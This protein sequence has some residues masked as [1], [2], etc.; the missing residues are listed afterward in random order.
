MGIPLRILL[1]SALVFS[2]AA[3]ADDHPA[4][5][6]SRPIAL[7]ELW[8]DTS[9]THALPHCFRIYRRIPLDS[10]LTQQL[11]LYVVNPRTWKPSDRRPAVVFIHGGGW[12]QG[13]PDQWFPQC[14]YFALRGAVGV[15]VQYRLATGTNTP[16]SCLSDCEA[17][18]AYLRRYA[19]ELGVD[20][21][22]IAVVGESAG[23]HLAA[24]LGTVSVEAGR[25]ESVP[26][27]LVLLNPITDLTTTWGQCWGNSAQ[28]FSPLQHICKGSP[29]TLLIHGQADS[30]V[31]IFHARAFHQRMLEL[32]NQC[33][34]IEVP[35]A[36][37]AFAVFGFGPPD[38]N[39]LAI[40]EIDRYLCHLGYL[41]GAQLPLI[42]TRAQDESGGRKALDLSL[43]R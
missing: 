22:R 38:G 28:K 10:G 8:E 11:R 40:F 13:D 4:S 24:A 29:P 12:S 32:R 5:S 25:S 3:A 14:R 43:D 17:A 39:I 21:K 7:A 26:D 18:I 36:D 30:V 19:H 33:R 37:H 41:A 27:A 16:A 20:P 2:V 6:S 15:S 35:G 9:L 1:A 31:D 42:P 23:G 34:L